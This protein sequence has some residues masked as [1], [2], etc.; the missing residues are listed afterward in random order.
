MVRAGQVLTIFAFALAS[1]GCVERRFVITTEPFGAT[2]YD[3][4]N[5]NIGMAPAD[6]S[7]VYYGNYRFTLVKDGYQTKVVE[8]R[9]RAPWYAWPGFDFVS[10]NLLPFTV[11]DIR[12]L[13][14]KLDP[15]EPVSPDTV[16]KDGNQIR[17]RGQTIGTDLPP[18]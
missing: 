8:E 17:Q 11:R 13:H 10:E 9:I 1:A 15:V 18:Q 3:P 16:L 5:V 12:R 7:F 6:K 14:Y 4:S 2:V